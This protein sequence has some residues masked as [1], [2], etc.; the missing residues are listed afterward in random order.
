ML[1]AFREGS[2]I[3]HCGTEV[4]RQKSVAFA[5]SLLDRRA[6]A[7]MQIAIDDRQRWRGT[8]KFLAA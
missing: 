6:V 3:S 1:R 5:R 8:H 7:A 2:S 4:P